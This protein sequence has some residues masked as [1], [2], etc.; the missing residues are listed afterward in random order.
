[1]FWYQQK[2]LATRNTH[3]QYKSPVSSSGSKVMAEDKV[4]TDR[5]NRQKRVIS[6]LSTK[7]CLRGFNNEVA[8]LL[9]FP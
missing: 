7:L 3:V 4:F 5:M 2:G 8:H 9:D 1:M 6:Y